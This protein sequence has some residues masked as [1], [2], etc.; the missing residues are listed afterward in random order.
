[1]NL[2][3]TR[4]VTTNVRSLAEFYETIT[5]VAPVYGS[6]EFA[7][8]R[9]ATGTLAI[10]SVRSSD[11]FGAGAATAASNRS[12]VIEFMV[13]DVDAERERLRPLVARC[14]LEPT[15]QPWGNRSMLFRDPDGNLINF[16]K[17]LKRAAAE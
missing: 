9:T 17:P 12:V 5:G 10:N 14:E 8:L 6:E 1:M 11:R 4:I 2:A 15:N 7:E 13:D 16:Y 3:S